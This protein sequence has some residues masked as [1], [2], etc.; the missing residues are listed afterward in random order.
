MEEKRVYEVNK[1]NDLEIE[2]MKGER[3]L[4]N[5]MIDLRKKL[6]EEAKFT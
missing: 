3:T 1:L 5:E 4:Q 2:A 6:E